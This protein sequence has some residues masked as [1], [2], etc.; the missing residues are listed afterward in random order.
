MSDLDTKWDWSRASRDINHNSRF[1]VGA[2]EILQLQKP[3]AISTPK[4]FLALGAGSAGSETEFINSFPTV[5]RKDFVDNHFTDDETTRWRNEGIN[6]HERGIFDFL[7]DPTTP[8]YNLITLFGMEFMTDD[9]P[10]LENLARLLSE[11]VSADGI[12][13]VT[14]L[15]KKRSSSGSK[16]RIDIWTEN[17]FD[18]T[19]PDPDTGVAIFTKRSE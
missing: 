17:G 12:V 13:L 15:Q 8:K 19:M 18:C 7:Q 10:T 5:L 14:Y 11:K 3:N 6:V 4:T 9:I 2:F 1:G 16:S